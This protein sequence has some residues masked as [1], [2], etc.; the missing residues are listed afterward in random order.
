MLYYM[1]LLCA[2]VWMLY[3][4]LLLCVQ[5]CGCSITCCCCVEEC[6][7]GALLHAAV[8][9]RSVGAGTSFLLR[10]GEV[11]LLCEVVSL[12]H[13]NITETV[14]CPNNDKFI[15]NRDPAV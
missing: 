10:Q 12:P 5:E 1:V 4:M 9:C 14:H 2:G 7:V 3:Y 11:S 15:I 8:V 13:Y 6:G